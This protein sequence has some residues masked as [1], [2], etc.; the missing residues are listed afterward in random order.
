MNDTKPINHE[1]ALQYAHM[2]EHDSNLARCYLELAAIKSQ[3]VPVAWMYHDGESPDNPPSPLVGSTLLS[4]ERMPNYRNERAL[5]AHLAPLQPVP[6]E[7]DLVRIWRKAYGP[8]NEFLVYIDTLQSELKVAQQELNELRALNLCK[9]LAEKDREGLLA[10]GKELIAREQRAE[11]AEAEH[12][13]CK[14]IAWDWGQGATDAETA[15]RQ[16]HKL[17]PIDAELLKEVGE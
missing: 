13:K 15:I 10:V 3:P 6:V 5:Y 11:K 9:G 8:D 17:F 1:E 2:H 4:F 12:D 16:L 7:P 14:R